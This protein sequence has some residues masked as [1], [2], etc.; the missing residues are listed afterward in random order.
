ML[1]KYA[2]I[3]SVYMIMVLSTMNGGTIDN[4]DPGFAAMAKLAPQA[5]SFE[6]SSAIMSKHVSEARVWVTPFWSGR[7]QLLKDDGAPVE[8]AIPKEGTIP[9][10]ATLNVPTGAK[11]KDNALKF[12]N[13]FL[14]KTS[15][16]AWVTGYNVGSI[17]TD[18]DIAAEVRKRQITSKADIDK[19]HLPNLHTIAKKRAEWGARW[20][21]EVSAAAD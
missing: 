11:N 1:P 13:F 15:Q 17:R 9:L 3:M 8:Y 6:Q 20:K 12:V 19:L 18:L 16:E 14:D 4:V 5:L 2:N 10:I 7:A 21:R